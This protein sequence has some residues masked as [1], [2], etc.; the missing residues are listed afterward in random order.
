MNTEIFERLRVLNHEFY[1]TFAE[2]FADKRT[3]L[4]PGVVRALEQIS[5]ESTIL[6]LGCGHGTLAES[7]IG[8]GHEGIYLGLDL[9]AGMIALARSAI[10]KP[11]VHFAQAD[12]SQGTWQELFQDVPTSFQP[13]YTLVLSFASLHHIPGAD[14]RRALVEEVFA[15]L[16]PGCR[17]ILSVWDFMRSE[18]LRARILPWTSVG[19]DPDQVEE[20]DTLIDW[21]HGGQGVRYVHHFTP[22]ALG[23]LAREAGFEVA[24]TYRMDGENSVLGLYQVWCKP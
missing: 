22:E 12:L 14:R 6:D 1:Q 18:R 24:D 20:G 9:S 5:P 17:W 7:L 13:P 10:D 11:S 23:D 21:R 8:R 15:L 3:R 16:K 4:Q 19:I 2:R